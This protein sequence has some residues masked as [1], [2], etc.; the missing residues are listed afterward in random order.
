[1]SKEKKGSI[2]EELSKKEATTKDFN[3][4]KADCYQLE[5]KSGRKDVSVAVLERIH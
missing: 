5:K 2:R 1:M 4:E 3:E